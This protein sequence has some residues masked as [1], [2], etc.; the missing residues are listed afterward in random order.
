MG[1][2]SATKAA[3]HSFSESLDMELCPFGV[4]VMLLAPGMIRS[5]IGEN[6]AA[7]R[8]APPADSLYTAFHKHLPDSRKFTQHSSTTPADAFARAVV[9][10]ALAQRPPRYLSIG[11]A[12]WFVYLL[13]WLPYSRRLDMLWKAFGKAITEKAFAK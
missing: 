12:S 5:N 11:H 1:T 3:L 13:T 6:A 9:D 7:L 4:R 8:V 10:A 2:Y